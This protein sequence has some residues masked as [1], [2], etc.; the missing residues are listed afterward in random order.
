[1]LKV[2]RKYNKVILVVGGTLL[3]V[4]FLM[5]Q[6]I[7]QLGRARMGKSIG[8]MD[9]HKIT[10]S[11][12]DLATRELHAME[13]FFTEAQLVFPIGRDQK[14]RGD[15]WL[16][17]TAEAEP[18]GE[19]GGP[20]EGESLIPVLAEE[21]AYSELQRQSYSPPDP[22]IVQQFTPMVQ[23]V[24]EKAKA[25][26]A[27]SARMMPEEFD[28]ALARLR[29][30]W[31]ML[32]MYKD[33][34]RLSDRQTIAIADK[35]TDSVVID[36]VFLD[37]VVLTDETLEPTPEQ[38]QA[39]FERFRDL[40]RGEGEFGIGYRLPPRVK[41]EWI[42]LDRVGMGEAIK[43]SLI[44][45]KKHWQLNRDEFPGLFEAER[46]EIEGILRKAEVDRVMGTADSVLRSAV[47]TVLRPFEKDGAYR[48]LPDNWAELKPDYT[49][50]AEE[51]VSTV[52]ERH[53]ITIPLPGV[54]IRNAEWLDGQGLRELPG[55]GAAQV[56]FERQ[57]FS[58]PQA[59]ML[60][61]GLSDDN[62]F[63]V[64]I[65]V[66][67]V[68]LTAMS[69]GGN[70]YYFTVLDAA[71]EGVPASIEELLDPDQLTTDWRA[72]Q[73]YDALAAAA[74]GMKATVA[75]QGL[76][77]FAKS[78]GA[79][80]SAPAPEG[81]TPPPPQD[82]VLVQRN[83]RVVEGRVQGMANL[84]DSQEVI[85]AVLAQAKA[86][87]P[88]TPID[89]IPLDRRVVAAPVPGRLGVLVAQINGVEPLTREKLTWAADY[90]KRVRREE[91]FAGVGIPFPFQ[92]PVLKQRHTFS[93]KTAS[94]D[95]GAETPAETTPADAG[96]APEQ[97]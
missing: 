97:G 35:A 44:D 46:E 56:T 40:R 95:E 48:V 65:G 38:L 69:A 87:D 84:S 20:L 18:A 51:I 6:A 10:L 26:A 5:P 50:L 27:G 77:A 67:A 71:P 43:I 45:S 11:R 78:F 9:G 21:I 58:F 14:S 83:A 17:L 81:T 80:E 89:E 91:T 74:E 30:V 39:H 3:M 52:R 4:A 16:L 54:Y 96:D 19:V 72:L 24:L 63:G 47:L 70:K 59:A 37:A 31:R 33:A 66:P 60:V 13:A 23:Q 85:E 61:R 32:N 76:E 8:S 42:E 36:G 29:G 92:F 64:Q 79:R 2:M 53:G 93:L 68:D 28:Q 49:K 25:Q 75:E 15:H 86:I 62:P 94:D 41:I 90:A 1:M 55:I 82:K 7:Q 88:M 12:Y 22:Q 34:E 73:R 57:R